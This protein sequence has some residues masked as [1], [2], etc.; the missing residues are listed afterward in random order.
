[1]NEDEMMDLGVLDVDENDEGAVKE[2]Y[3]AHTRAMLKKGKYYNPCDGCS[4][5]DCNCCEFGRGM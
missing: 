2:W 1:M 3:E 4:G 5:E